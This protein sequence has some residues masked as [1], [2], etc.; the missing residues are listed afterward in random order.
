MPVTNKG[1]EEFPTTNGIMQ[2][3]TGILVGGVVPI[4]IPPPPQCQPPRFR[5]PF[6]PP[7]LGKGIR[8]TARIASVALMLALKTAPKEPSPNSGGCV[9]LTEIFGR[10]LSKKCLSKVAFVVVKRHG[11]EH[12][13]KMIK[14]I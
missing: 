12:H 9:V 4:Y 13:Q 5:E 8:F 14:D 1:L 3:V 11:M 7:A 2:V 10:G 6:T